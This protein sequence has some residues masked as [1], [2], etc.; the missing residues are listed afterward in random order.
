MQADCT[1]STGP[2]EEPANVV[3]GSSASSAH[4]TNRQQCFFPFSTGSPKVSDVT[5]RR[6]D[7][8]RWAPCRWRLSQGGTEHSTRTPLPP[9]P[10]VPSPQNLPRRWHSSY[11]RPGC[12]KRCST[13][14]FGSPSPPKTLPRRL[15]NHLSQFWSLAAE[16]GIFDGKHPVHGHS[17]MR[18][19]GWELLFALRFCFAKLLGICWAI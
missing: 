17:L 14:L 5:E 13:S 19:W 9:P 2:T 8:R 16:V 10:P 6:A 12:T 3:A 4:K 15:C 7:Q 1:C 18:C 11:K